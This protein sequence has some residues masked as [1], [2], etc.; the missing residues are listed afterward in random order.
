MTD[1]KI[2]NCMCIKRHLGVRKCT[3]LLWKPTS[4]ARNYRGSRAVTASLDGRPHFWSSR[5]FGLDSYQHFTSGDIS[6][7]I[8]V[9]DPIRPRSTKISAYLSIFGRLKR[10]TSIRCHR[11]T[12]LVSM[13]RNGVQ[14][15]HRE[16][17]IST[18]R[19]L[20]PEVTSAYIMNESL[21]PSGF[22]MQLLR[23]CRNS[24][25]SDGIGC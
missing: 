8:Q 15:A 5:T 11:G 18:D 25:V 21:L 24:L 13:R 12:I 16:T 9:W 3:W 7:P 2:F 17:S 19:L 10:L 23:L 1:P 20:K 6:F 22:W 14:N 4:F